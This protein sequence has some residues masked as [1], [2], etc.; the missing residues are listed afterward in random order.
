M[1]YPCSSR[2][3]RTRG[4]ATHWSAWWT[5]SQDTHG[6]QSR[7][8]TLRREQVGWKGVC[9]PGNIRALTVDVTHK[10]TARKREGVALAFFFVQW[11][12]EHP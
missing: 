3:W 6:A 11:L 5:R 2:E 1:S 4:L 10:A 9:E 12:L 7:A 8:L